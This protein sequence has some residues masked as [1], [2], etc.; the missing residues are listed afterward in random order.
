M[1][2]VDAIVADLAVGNVIKAIDQVGDGGLACAG[3][4]HKGD[5]LARL[6]ID[7]HI[8]QHGLA[9]LVAKV[10]I[11]QAHV[12]LQQRI[13][14]AAIGLRL[15][16]GP[17]AGVTGRFR[18]GA[19]RSHHRID[20]R[21]LALILLRLLVH[22][23]EDAA[24]AGQTHDDGVDLLG[25]LVHIAS[26]LL[27]HVQEGDEHTDVKGH[28]GDAHIG[29]AGE[30]QNAAHH[31]NEHIEDVAQIVDDGAKNVGVGVRPA[32]VLI[33]LV[34]DPVKI[35][36][37]GGLMAE[38]LDHLLAVHYL[39][40]E[41]LGLPHGFLLP[42][43]VFG[44]AAAH[45]FGNDGHER[46]AQQHQKGHPKAVIEHDAEHAGDDHAGPQQRGQRLRDQL[47]QGV[48]VVGVIAHD[49]P[50]AMGIKIADG[51]ILH[52]VEHGPADL[53]KKALGDA[54]HQLAVADA[55]KR[56]QNVKPAQNGEQR[57]DLRLG[58]GP[59]AGGEPLFDDGDDLLLEDSGDGGGHRVEQN[60]EGGH[61]QQHGE[62]AEQQLQKPAENALPGRGTALSA[63]GGHGPCGHGTGFI[64]GRCLP[65]SA[66]CRS[67]DR[68]RWRP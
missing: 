68:W 7:G 48:G 17:V 18:D 57:H 56:R 62:G 55:G 34:V 8:V 12:A 22:Q 40:N 29:D 64:H 37:A 4:A 2:D 15:L 46:H 1:V 11:L 6:R 63:G 59:V 47:P 9:F 28:A 25:K 50:V 60:A 16:P 19:V 23:V 38:D 58:G 67:R 53:V 32:A 14:K 27:G 42:D 61:R 10:H 13:G 33:K 36:L 5:L 65:S 20:Q 30:Q 49:I 24:R 66:G 51:Q 21:H 54:C 39:L 44:G 3:G 43:K 31:C 35:R 52:A 26:E 41:A 45:L